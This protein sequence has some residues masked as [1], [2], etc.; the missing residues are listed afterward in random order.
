MSIKCESIVKKK[1]LRKSLITVGVSHE[2]F[3]NF[4]NLW[5]RLIKFSL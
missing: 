5:I 1:E 2:G 4:Y 3:K